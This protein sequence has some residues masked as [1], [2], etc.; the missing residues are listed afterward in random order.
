MRIPEAWLT[1]VLAAATAGFASSAE[2]AVAGRV[3]SAEGSPIPGAAV[4]AF[5]YENAEQAGE[6]RV[7][8]RAR[9]PVATVTT[10]ADGSFRI[11]SKHAFASV[12]ASAEGHAPAAVP[13]ADGKTEPITLMRAALRR[14]LIAAGGKPVSGAVVFW[15][16]QDGAE[17]MARTGPAGVFEAP[18]PSDAPVQVIVVH[19]DFALVWT[20]AGWPGSKPG[21]DQRLESGMRLVGSVVDDDT[22]RPVVDARIWIDDT[23]PLART[24]AKGGFVIPHASREWRSVTA[25]TPQRVGAAKR[26]T[27]PLVVRMKPARTL[28]GTVTDMATRQALSGATVTVPTSSITFRSAITDARGQ[29]TLGGLPPGRYQPHVGRAGYASAQPVPQ[30][31]GIDLRSAA[32]ARFDASLS[33]LPL[34]QGRVED[35]RHRPVEGA[36]VSLGLKDSPNVYMGDSP[37]IVTVFGNRS[38]WTTA[39][40]SFTLAVEIGGE[41][42]QDLAALLRDQR[43]MVL[44]HGFAAAQAP[45]AVRDGRPA[46]VAVTLPA[47]LELRGRITGADG[48]PVAGVAVTAAEDGSIGGRLFPTEMLLQSMKDAGWTTSDEAGRFALHVHAVAH[49]L[50][51]RKA[52]YA[53]QLTRNHDPRDGQPLEVVL[54]PAA[55]VRGRVTRA[56]GRGVADA[57]VSLSSPLGMASGHPATTSADGAFAIADLAPGVY[58][59][60]VQ[61]EALGLH[62]KRTIE[63]PSAGLEIVL[64]PTVTLRGRVLDAASRQPVTRFQVAVESAGERGSTSRSV[65]AEDASGSFTVE[66][67]ATGEARLTVSAEGFAR[68]TVEGLSLETGDEPAAVEVLLEAEAPIRGRVTGERGAPVAEAAVSLLGEERDARAATDQDGEYELR[69][70][71]PGETTLTFEAQGYVTEK[72]TIDSRESSRLD[73][74]LKRGLTLKGEV[75]KAGVGV[76]SAFVG[77]QSSVRG[78]T[79]QG[80]QTDAQGRFAIA[81]LVPGRYT[82]S[83]NARGQGSARLEDVDAETAGP[84]RLTLDKAA[85][86]VIHGKVVG[87]PEGDYGMTVVLAT[88][89]ESGESAQT[90]VDSSQ[91]F[92]ME[93]APSGRVRVR[94][95]AVSMNEV[96][97]QYS[98]TVELNLAPGS[99][100]ET[101]LEFAN[102][103]TITGTVTRDGA[104]VP[105]VSLGFGSDQRNGAVTR[106]DPR[107]VYQVDLEPGSYR[108]AVAG[109]GVS[110]ETE[111]VVTA[112]AQFDIDVT[113]G[114]IAG[115][116][117]RADGGTPLPG[118]QIS[119]FRLGGGENTPDGS[120]STGSQGTFRQ[121]SLR[122]GRYR[123]I[124]SKAGYGQEVRDVEVPRGGTAEVLIELEPAEGVSVTVVD[125]RDS[126]PLEAIVVVRDQARRIVANRHSGA[127]A[128][129]LLNIPL[130]DGSYLLSTSAS[131]YGT[132]TIPV[133]APTH[134]LR[135]GLTPGG[136]LIIESERD[137]RGRVRLV[138]P[139]GEE[140]V[141]CW[142][143]GIAE[144]QLKGRRTSVENITPGSYTLEIVDSPE[145]AAPRPVV[146]REGQT[147]TVAIE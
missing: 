77:A 64:A 3:L 25:T 101:V 83:A 63:A 40:G 36:L 122:E 117:V 61:H 10:E 94:A 52:G 131:G 44:K 15:V 70:L 138:Q 4:E 50:F 89:A 127:D 95:S 100:T 87:L 59:L 107:G 71:P 139:D 76:P 31:Q 85:T 24:D 114:S 48:R 119:L 19:P 16:S 80:A 58:E 105:F 144:I 111:Y 8:G 37:G 126:R 39:D 18:G 32:T 38:A 1:A 90:S 67:V 43:L 34:I 72:R 75:V 140:Y 30:S 109:D 60:S 142:C 145:A 47:G 46:P 102:D 21:I 73:V 116:V 108:V 41:A 65:E 35:E 20:Y 104:G 53:P 132:V 106:A 27:G 11:E 68:K 147:S 17:R 13:V 26:R 130:A 88:S 12:Q 146:I 54:E 124:T 103:V 6:R 96:A 23:W 91:A 113:G 2:A 128:S 134:D 56:D 137:L 120:A 110:F 99:E 45:L 118:V 22:G 57:E 133:T 33:R 7:A 79:Y 136:T 86:A 141:R 66:D 74:T 82:I 62:H 29:Y 49:H 98:R 81:G 5:E 129:G 92:R 115:R 51:F 84:L 9:T 55:S 97:A 14:G 125:A 135:V 121:P 69:G 143:N 78:A 123:L 112:P 93:D 28:T 42:S